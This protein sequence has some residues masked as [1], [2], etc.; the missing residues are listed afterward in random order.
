MDPEASAKLP[1]Y[2]EHTEELT[3]VCS[4][5]R[6]TLYSRFFQTIFN[7]ALHLGAGLTCIPSDQPGIAIE[8]GVLILQIQISTVLSPAM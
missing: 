6:K 4:E 3:V 5:F 1:G 7:I 2:C 8:I